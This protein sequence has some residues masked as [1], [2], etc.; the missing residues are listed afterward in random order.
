MQIFSYWKFIIYKLKLRK[1]GKRQERKKICGKKENFKE[2][3][4]DL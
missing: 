2:N 1:R 4:D 3:K